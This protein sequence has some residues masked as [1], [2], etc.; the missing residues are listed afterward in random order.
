[1]GAAAGPGRDH[2]G[3]WVLESLFQYFYGVLWRNLAQTAQHELRM[4]AYRHIQDLEMQWFSEQS[5]GGLMAIM[6]DD[7]NQLERFLDHGANDLLQVG[8]TVIVVS[9]IMFFLA[10]EVAL[11]AIIPSRDSRRVLPVPEEDRRQ[12]L[13][14]PKGGGRAER[15]PEQQPQGIT[16]IK[17]FTAEE[18]EA[19]RV[20]DASQSYRDANRSAIRLSASFV[21]LI[22]MAI[23]FAFTAN[24]LVGGKYALEGKIGLGEYSVIVFI[25]QRLLWPLTRLGETFDLYQRALA[26][27]TR[28]LDLLD[29]E[30]GWLRATPASRKSRGHQVRGH[31]VHVPGKGG[32]PQGYRSRGSSREDRRVGRSH[33]FRQDHLGEAPSEV[34]RPPG[35]QGVAGWA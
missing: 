11:L 22:R 1:M 32:R 10:P 5:T 12:V 15:H 16:T 6:N 30:V 19:K 9:G 14:G 23:L 31:P 3:I 27:T 4:D 25:T 28:V 8:T 17:S 33:G 20:S 18:R 2:R 29:T 13:R 26:S 21:P 24:L 34:P 7:V 35:G